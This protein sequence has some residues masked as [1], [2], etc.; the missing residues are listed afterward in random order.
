M[1]P[2]TELSIGKPL[3]R[4]SRPIGA[5]HGTVPLRSFN[6]ETAACGP[7]TQAR[8]G[9]SQAR[10]S[11]NKIDCRVA[12]GLDAEMRTLAVLFLALITSWS[13]RADAPSPP[14]PLKPVTPKGQPPSPAALP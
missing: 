12:S 14:A 9:H 10:R 2:K 5:E 1:S 13:A 7:A 11:R 3:P 8:P 6:H 4:S